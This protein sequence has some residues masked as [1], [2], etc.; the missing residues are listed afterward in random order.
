MTRRG[1]DAIGD[2]AQPRAKRTQIRIFGQGAWRQVIVMSSEET[3]E[4]LLWLQRL[5]SASTE[6]RSAPSP[7]WIVLKDAKR[8]PPPAANSF[9]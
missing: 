4:W 2:P 8:T 7:A 6:P 9:S 1:Q 3:G 5:V